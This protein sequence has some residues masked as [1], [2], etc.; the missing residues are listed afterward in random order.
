[1]TNEI[2]FITQIASII[3][4]IGALF[5]LYR[6]LISQKDATIE[7]LKEKNTFLKEQLDISQKNTPDNLAKILS[8]RIHILQEEIDRLSKDQESNKDRIAKKEKYLQKLEKQLAEIQE[9][10]SEYFCPHCKS[11]LVVQEY[12]S[13]PYE[14]GDIDHEYIAFECGYSIVDGK[15]NS[16]CKN[17]EI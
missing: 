7:L 9:I 4:F 2:I 8:E 10:A 5:I 1:M 13:E 15:E 11:R 16:P 14:Y 6:V 3:S 12:H 17:K